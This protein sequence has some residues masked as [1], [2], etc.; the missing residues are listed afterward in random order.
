M[1]I[2][3]GLIIRSDESLYRVLYI[4]PSTDMCF[5]IQLNENQFPIPHFLSEIEASLKEGEYIIEEN[6]PTVINVDEEELT[7]KEKQIRDKAHSIVKSIMIEPNIYYKYTRGKLINEASAKFNVA[8]KTIRDYLKRYW[9]RG[10]TANALLPN[11]YKCGKSERHYQTK[12]GRRIQYE[13]AI[14]RGIVTEQWKQFFKKG[15][16]KYY[17][18]MKETTLKF[19]YEQMLKDYFS[20]EDPKTGVKILNLTEPIPSF[21]QFQYWIQKMYSPSVIAREREGYRY[22]MQNYRPTTGST[23]KDSGSIGHYAI[24][25]T[26][27]DIY[28]CNPLQR[29]EIISRPIVYLSVD[30]FSRMIVGVYATFESASKKAL[31]NTLIHTFVDKSM[32]YGEFGIDNEKWPS[33]Y[34][35][36]VLLCDRGSEFISNELTFIAEMLNITV[37]NTGSY[38]AEMKSVV[39]N[40]F[41]VV[42]N[43]LIGI[44]PGAVRK[45]FNKRGNVQPKEEAVLTLKEYTEILIKSAVHFNQ[46]VL[47]NYPMSLEMIENDIYPTPQTIFEHELKHTLLRSLSKN[48][49]NALLLP[50][51][52]ALVTSKG[53]SFRGLYYMSE[54]ALKNKWLSDARTVGNWQVDIQYNEDDVSEIYLRHNRQRIEICPLLNQYQQY[55]GLSFEELESWRSRQRKRIKNNE[56]HSINARMLLTQEIEGIV[57]QAKMDAETDENTMSY[58]DFDY[59]MQNDHAKDD[60]DTTMLNLLKN[61]QVRKNEDL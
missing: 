45:N 55:K 38:R 53:I 50:F 59:R 42:Q 47:K 14:K 34:L 27:A 58:K 5:M 44:L 40:Y 9:Q 36:N 25:A 33:R 18:V 1:V 20:I 16:E 43:N 57:Q 26:I 30:I 8:E 28:L 37:Q 6:D 29:N 56:E 7:L 19:S 32:L 35:P 46:R 23:V 3:K 11:Y 61:M 52:K 24:D 15:F 17:L 10:M 48:Q 54:Y 49:L 4:D 60:Y 41:H 13:T 12:T 2:T 31:R 39:E 21:R 22:F 51:A